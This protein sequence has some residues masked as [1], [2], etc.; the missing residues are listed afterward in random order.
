MKKVLENLG[1]EVMLRTNL[2]QSQMD[3]AIDTHSIL[4]TMEKGI[5]NSIN[6]M[7]LDACRDDPFPSIDR[8]LNRGLGRINTRGSII[9]FA[10]A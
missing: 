9:A 5:N 2:T 4:K 1:F 10:Q 3:D 7:I 8:N 6:I